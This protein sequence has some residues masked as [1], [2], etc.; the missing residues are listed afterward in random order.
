MTNGRVSL[1]RSITRWRWYKDGNA[2]RLFIHCI[3][4]ANYADTPWGNI[5]LHRGEFATSYE[6]LSNDLG[7][8]VKEVRTALGKLKRTGEVACTSTS[9]YTVISIP[10]YDLYQ[11][12][13]NQ[14]GSQRAIEGQAEGKQRATINKDN[15]D[16]NIK[17]V[18]NKKEKNIKKESFSIPTEIAE[19][20]AGYVEMRKRNKNPMTDR[21]KKI[22]LNR[23]EALA[24][25]DYPAQIKLLDDATLKGWKSVYVS[26]EKQ[27]DGGGK[28]G[29]ADRRMGVDGTAVD[30]M[31]AVVI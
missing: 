24:P 18:E 8:T 30:T 16:I 31:S 21:A 3:L 17:E 28:N 4:M 29:Q 25:N 19:A 10:N 1:D 26:D 2:A 5:V 14:T 6:R 9:K 12:L 13:G 22:L 7:L 15:K 27:K 23:L 11:Y 20:F